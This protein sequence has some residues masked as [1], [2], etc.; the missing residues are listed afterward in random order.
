MIKPKVL[1]VDG[2]NYF[3]QCFQTN[4]SVDSNGE[5]NGGF[6]GF[7]GMIQKLVN[8]FSPQKLIVIFDGPEAGKR[9]KSLLNSYKDKRGS[10]KRLACVDFGDGEKEYVDNE[11][12]Q[13]KDTFEFLKQLPVHVLLVPYYE[14][15][16]VIAYLVQKNTDKLNIICS[17][18]RDFLQLVD[19]TTYVWSSQKKIL[20]TPEKLQEYYDIIPANF[21]LM[22]SI[23]GDTSDGLKGVKGI[24]MPTLFDIM[25]QIKTQSFKDF[26]DFWEEVER[27]EDGKGKT[28]KK[29]KENKDQAHLMYRLMKLDLTNLNQ[30]AIE[31]VQQ[32]VEEQ[33]EK[34]FS[35]MN[36][37]LYC[38]R[39]HL[40]AY[41]K[42][43][44]LW[45]QPFVFL[46][47]EITLLS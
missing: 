25:P 37:K 11:Q 24:G 27:L 21:V 17:T 4:K 46:K 40:E 38:I 41:I 47:Q 26:W 8:R 28:I 16:D 29:L 12:K 18:D 30:R 3:Y 39:E 5:P 9:R 7:I 45:I 10:K 34:P 35:K 20:F 6:V 14:A 31:Q 44:E 2:F 23:V 13:L 36:L 1:Y 43:F 15:D 42:N 33:K 32:Q 22:R 19:D